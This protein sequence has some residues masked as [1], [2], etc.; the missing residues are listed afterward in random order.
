MSVFGVFLVRIFPHSDSPYSVQMR[1]NTDQK[2]SEYEH[3]SHSDNCSGL[4][5]KICLYKDYYPKILL[6]V[7]SSD[8]TCR[9][10][11]FSETQLFKPCF[12]P[13]SKKRFLS[14]FWSKVPPSNNFDHRRWN[15]EKENKRQ[16]NILCKRW[17][18]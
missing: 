7:N 18:G 2:I 9:I 12:F 1:E 8:E 6:P 4:I 17:V 13:L 11:T 16:K 5:F 3:I 15:Y 10:N 14:D